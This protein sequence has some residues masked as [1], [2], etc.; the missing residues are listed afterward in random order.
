MCFGQ[1]SLLSMVLTSVLLSY[2]PIVTSGIH[3]KFTLLNFAPAVSD[4]YILTFVCIFIEMSYLKI[5]F[6]TDQNMPT[7]VF[8]WLVCTTL[9][10]IVEEGNQ[11]LKAE[12]ISDYVD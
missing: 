8:F 6:F 11:P 2:C 1:A 9:M 10:L 12:L 5:L 4:I 7:M 3:C